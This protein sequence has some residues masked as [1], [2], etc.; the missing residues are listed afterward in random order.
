MF[1]VENSFIRVNGP[2]VFLTISNFNITQCSTFDSSIKI[3]LK[4]KE[5]FI[6]IISISKVWLSLINCVSC[7]KYNYVAIK[8]HNVIADSKFLY[9]G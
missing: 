2:Q 1:L 8:E 6:S 7:E 4:I 5:A 9:N 3:I